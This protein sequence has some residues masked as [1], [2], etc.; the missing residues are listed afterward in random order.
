MTKSNI[1]L[2][3]DESEWQL[4]RIK[5]IIE[6]LQRLHDHRFMIRDIIRILRNDEQYKTRWYY[7]DPRIRWIVN[8]V[9]LAYATEGKIKILTCDRDSI[10]EASH[11][12]TKVYS[13]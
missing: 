2:S 5:D 13:R 3:N 1:N 8:Q 12:F 6:Y 11:D 4:R 9:L 7:S 10:F